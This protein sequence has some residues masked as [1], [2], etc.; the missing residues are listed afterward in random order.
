MILAIHLA[1][2]TGRALGMR[3]P[4]PPGKYEDKGKCV[5]CE[6]GT[7]GALPNQHLSCT[8]CRTNTFNPARGSRANV[9]LACPDETTSKGG[10]AACK[11]CPEGLARQGGEYCVRC[12][13]GEVVDGT[14]CT[15]CGLYYSIS[16]TVNGRICSRC[17]AGQIANSEL[18]KCLPTGCRPGFEVMRFEQDCTPCM[19]GYFNDGSLTECTRCPTRFEPTAD[20]SGCTRCRAGSFYGNSA[21]GCVKCPTGQTTSGTGKLQCTKTGKEC[22]KQDNFIDSDGDCDKC[23]THER[24][25][26]ANKK[27]VACPKKAWS[28][29]GI[30]RNCIRQRC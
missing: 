19:D 3:P 30:P 1:L 27:C 17:P 18:T 21:L 12:P 16:P 24:L 26:A 11:P 13:P 5:P 7:F 2:L 14:H 29:G 25:D 28:T 22:P 15:L 6:R 10:A 23:S 4:C 9:C 20:A 8:S